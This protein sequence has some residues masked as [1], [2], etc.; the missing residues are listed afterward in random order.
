MAV[1]EAVRAET[2]ATVRNSMIRAERATATAGPTA[3]NSRREI[4]S[5]R[6]ESKSKEVNSSR[7]NRNTREDQNIRESRQQQPPAVN[8][9]GTP[10][11]AGMPT[12]TAEAREISRQA[13]SAWTLS[14][15]EISTAVRTLTTAVASNNF[16]SNEASNVVFLLTVKLRMLYQF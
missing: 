2:P 13:T 7:T 1:G 15:A 11:T 6:N 10:A 12:A 5:S 4:S 14:P 3:K 8:K 9:V 16:A